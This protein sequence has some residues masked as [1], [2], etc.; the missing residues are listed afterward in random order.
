MTHEEKMK[1]FRKEMAPNWLQSGRWESFA[2]IA[3]NGNLQTLHLCYFMSC[4]ESMKTVCFPSV[5]GKLA[6]V[7]E[8]LWRSSSSAPVCPRQLCDCSLL[9]SVMSFSCFR[10][11]PQTSAADNALR[12]LH[13]RLCS[14][15]FSVV[16]ACEIQNTLP[17]LPSVCSWYGVLPL[18]QLEQINIFCP[19]PYIFSKGGDLVLCAGTSAGDWVQGS[20]AHLHD[21]QQPQEPAAAALLCRTPV[22]LAW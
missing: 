20:I 3:G 4:S 22:T 21:G 11:S 7:D 5:P 6:H 14:Q 13:K 19:T 12:L 1:E 18:C 17:A 10:H 2:R 15:L 16:R 8:I 9:G